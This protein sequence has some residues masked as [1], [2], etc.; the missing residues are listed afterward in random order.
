MVSAAGETG[1]AA[2]AGVGAVVGVPAVRAPLRL[3]ARQSSRS[4]V[5]FALVTLSF[6]T[7]RLD[8]HRKGYSHRLS[9]DKAVL[10]F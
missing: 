2:P 3:G 10:K 7:V 9:E 1:G 4:C 6:V 5:Q 8:W